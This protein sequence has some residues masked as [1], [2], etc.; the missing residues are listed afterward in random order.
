[1]IAAS[2]FLCPSHPPTPLAQP[3]QPWQQ[4]YELEAEAAG[5]DRDDRVAALDGR[6]IQQLTGDACLLVAHEDSGLLVPVVGD[7]IHEPV[8]VHF[9][10]VSADRVGRRSARRTEGQRADVHVEDVVY[11]LDETA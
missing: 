3:D 8:S 10:G 9:L 1:M 6:A 11:A 5:A 7:E 4:E 2:E